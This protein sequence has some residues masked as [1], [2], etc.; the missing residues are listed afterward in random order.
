MERSRRGKRHAAQRGLVSVLCGA[1]YGYRYVSK[2]LAGGQAHYQVIPEQ[3]RV[4]KQIFEWVILWRPLVARLG[5]A[6]LFRFATVKRLPNTR[7]FERL[8]ASHDQ[9]R[10]DLPKTRE[11]PKMNVNTTYQRGCGIWGEGCVSSL[12]GI[13]MKRH[14]HRY[15]RN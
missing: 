3:A 11:M 14:A 2:H 8:F 15:H 12:V 6:R 13:F 5:I 7:N 10:P 9:H 1:P 4:I